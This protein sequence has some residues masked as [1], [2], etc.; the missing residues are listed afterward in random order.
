KQGDTWKETLSGNEEELRGHADRESR[1]FEVVFDDPQLELLK[2][3][4]DA[5]KTVEL[6]HPLW[7]T[8]TVLLKPEQRVRLPGLTCGDALFFRMH[9]LRDFDEEPTRVRDGQLHIPVPRSGRWRR[10]GI[11]S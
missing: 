10:F 1:Q 4:F 9:G 11:G 3:P 7:G 5:I 8:A 6:R 2:L